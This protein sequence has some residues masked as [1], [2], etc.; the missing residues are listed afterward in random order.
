M[1]CPECQ[2]EFDD[3]VSEC[4]NCGMPLVVELRVDPY[5][6]DGFSE[7][8]PVL[9]T[10]N[11]TV[12]LMARSFLEEAGIDFVAM[13]EEPNGVPS[14]GRGGIIQSD[15]PVEFQVYPEDAL[16]ARDILI[17][18]IEGEEMVEE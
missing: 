5:P 8:V 10:S 14:T 13:G 7:R 4:P 9:V 15:K 18:L 17:D 12:A 16:E 1:F 3:S 11:R 6:D 2:M